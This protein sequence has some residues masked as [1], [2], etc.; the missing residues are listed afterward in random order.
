MDDRRADAGAAAFAGWL[1]YTKFTSQEAL[2]EFLAAAL[3]HPLSA[4]AVKLRGM[5]PM[6]TTG[7]REIRS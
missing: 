2:G 6:K 5:P 4:G 3:Q 7:E 1:N